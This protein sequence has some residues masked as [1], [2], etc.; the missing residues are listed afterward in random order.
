MHRFTALGVAALATV[1]AL[2]VAP[3]NAAPDPL[4]PSNPLA[5]TGPWR[6]STITTRANPELINY[7]A[8]TDP[9]RKAAL[10]RIALTPRVRWFAN[11]ASCNVSTVRQSVAAYVKDAQRGNPRALVQLAIFGLWPDGE[12]VRGKRP[13]MSWSMTRY[14]RWIK[15]IAAGIGTARVAIVLEPDLAISANHGNDGRTMPDP[16]PRTRMK[17][18]AWAAK[19]LSQ[20]LRREAIYLDAGSADWL[21]VD[22][23]VRLLKA[24]GVQYVRGFALGATH[25]DSVPANVAFAAKVSAALSRA[26]IKGKRA[27]LDTADNGTPFTWLQWNA[28]WGPRFHATGDLFYQF[29]NTPTCRSRTETV[30]QTL[31]HRPTT[32]MV[33]RD[34]RR[35]VDAYLWFGR[36]WRWMQQGGNDPYTKGRSI[37]MATYSPFR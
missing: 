6:A 31:G 22:E 1:L 37:R 5:D 3:A 15:Q 24:S 4:N 32:R 28:R 33:R 13:A 14:Q 30:C 8:E 18:A 19:Y 2:A 25:Y 34:A 35:Y 29:D 21:Y 16:T 11:C 26:G 17:M 27:V 9:V 20:T 36:G 10:G 23:A 12:V 7:R